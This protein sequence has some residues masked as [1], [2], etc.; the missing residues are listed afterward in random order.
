[1]AYK[2]PPLLMSF[3]PVTKQHDGFLFRTGGFHF[4]GIAAPLH[5]NIHI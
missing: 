1:M 4:S 5:R 3:A 2:T